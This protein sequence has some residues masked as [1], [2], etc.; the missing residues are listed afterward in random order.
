MYDPLASLMMFPDKI[1]PCTELL[2]L[3]DF[4]GTTAQPANAGKSGPFKGPITHLDVLWAANNKK[5]PS[6]GEASQSTGTLIIASLI[7]FRQEILSSLCFI[8]LRA[9]LFWPRPYR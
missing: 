3:I 8:S 9:Q 6:Q 2:P 4:H 7:F 5:P 1:L